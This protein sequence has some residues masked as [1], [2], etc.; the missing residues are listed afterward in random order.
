MQ[1]RTIAG[2]LCDGKYCV[3]FLVRSFVCSFV[4][5]IDVLA[6]YSSR[7]HTPPSESE[8]TFEFIISIPVR[9]SV[10]V[11]VA[12]LF[13]FKS[14]LLFVHIAHVAAAYNFNK[15]YNLL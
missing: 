8:Q 6:L 13:P 9:F 2:S 5:S 10:F 14:I 1:N 7:A 12:Q 15:Y 3:F 11:H 4:S